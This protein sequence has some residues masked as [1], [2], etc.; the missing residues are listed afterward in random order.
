MRGRYSTAVVVVLA[1]RFDTDR[2]PS[3]D[4]HLIS[5]SR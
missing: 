2:G 3:A 1:V 5:P 4:A